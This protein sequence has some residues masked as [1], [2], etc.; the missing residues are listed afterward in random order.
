QKQEMF[1]RSKKGVW[2]DLIMHSQKVGE[3][4]GVF[5]EMTDLYFDG[6]FKESRKMAEKVSELEHEADKIANKIRYD[7]SKELHPPFDGEVLILVNEQ[8]L[9][10]NQAENVGD[11]MR[12]RETHVPLELK[13]ELKKIVGEVVESAELLKKLTSELGKKIPECNI[14]KLSVL[15][16]QI[17]QNEHNADIVELEL[18]RKIYSLDGKIEPFASTHLLRLA[19]LI[20]IIPNSIADAGEQIRMIIEE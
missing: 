12:M 8:D 7:K 9:I 15:L 18:M 6:K 19:E 1:T 5:K 13:V 20:C 11:L 16:S 10:A 3:C 14:N 2:T 4:V 17:K